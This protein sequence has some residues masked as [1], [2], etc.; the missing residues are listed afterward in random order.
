MALQKKPGWSDLPPVPFEDHTKGYMNPWWGTGNGTIG[1]PCANDGACQDH[2]AEQFP[3]EIQAETGTGREALDKFTG[4]FSHNWFTIGELLDQ[5]LLN[6]G[7]FAHNTTEAVYW[8]ALKIGEHRALKD[9]FNSQRVVL[10]TM[11]KVPA[12]TYGW[13]TVFRG[14]GKAPPTSPLLHGE[15]FKVALA[16]IPDLKDVRT[17]YLVRLEGNLMRMFLLLMQDMLKSG[18]AVTAKD[19]LLRDVDDHV[20]S[21]VDELI[22]QKPDM[23]RAFPTMANDMGLYTDDLKALADDVVKRIT[24]A[25][26]VESPG[27]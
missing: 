9:I 17:P 21:E 18:A 14:D 26:D 8:N 23:V 1:A 11:A 4:D 24:A 13:A 20:T 19:E 5:G 10:Q 3:P 27:P 6:T 7:G 2:Y 12:G 15:W 16:G 25:K 22:K